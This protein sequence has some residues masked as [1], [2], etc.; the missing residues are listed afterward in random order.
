M[1]FPRFE[2]T[3]TGCVD[4]LVL[5]E[6]FEFF[7]LIGFDFCDSLSDLFQKCL[8]LFDNM[9]EAFLCGLGSR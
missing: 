4:F 3:E 6:P 2:D 8:S 1:L 7:G 5:I 9:S